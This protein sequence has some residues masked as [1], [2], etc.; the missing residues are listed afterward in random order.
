MSEKT[1]EVLSTWF[2]GFWSLDLSLGRTTEE[3][4]YIIGNDSTGRVGNLLVASHETPK[5]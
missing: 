5:R 1:V 3:R 4:K 2:E